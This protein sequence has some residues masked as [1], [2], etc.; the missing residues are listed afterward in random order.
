MTIRFAMPGA[1]RSAV[2]FCQRGLVEGVALD[3]R[4]PFAGEGRGFRVGRRGDRKGR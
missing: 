1:A 3:A 4:A 2:C